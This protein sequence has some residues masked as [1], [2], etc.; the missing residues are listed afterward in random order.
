MLAEGTCRSTDRVGSCKQ[1][2]GSSSLPVALSSAPGI[3][4]GRHTETD[5]AC[6]VAVQPAPADLRAY[7]LGVPRQSSGGMHI[8]RSEVFCKAGH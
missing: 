7:S 8:R 1:Q 5:E 6:F 3:Y 4:N 2:S